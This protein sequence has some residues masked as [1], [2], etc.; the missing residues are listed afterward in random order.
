MATI[1]WQC[2]ACG[3]MN[4]RRGVYPVTRL[5]LRCPGRKEP[6]TMLIKWWECVTVI[7]TQITVMKPPKKG[8]G[9]VNQRN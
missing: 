5:Q 8:A 7:P 2:N 4:Q 9:N 6:N 3:R 1:H